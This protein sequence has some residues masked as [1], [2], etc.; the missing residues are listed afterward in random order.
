MNSNGTRELQVK[1][2][3]GNLQ[4]KVSELLYALG[5]VKDSEDILSITFDTKALKEAGYKD[6]I[7]LTIKIRKEEEV[8][9]YYLKDG[10]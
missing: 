9:V 7:P 2:S 3:K 10:T 6:P 8:G 1:I 5:Y 4:D